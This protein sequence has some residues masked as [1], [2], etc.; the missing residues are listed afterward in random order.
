[1]TNQQLQALK[2]LRDQINSELCDSFYETSQE[3]REALDAVIKILEQEP[4]GDCVSRE[5]VFD[6]IIW[7]EENGVVDAR[8]IIEHIRKLPPATPTREH[9]EWLNAKVGKLFPSNDFKCNRCGNIL[10]F[11][12]VNAGR[13][14]ANFCPNC[15][16]KMV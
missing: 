16:A 10:D 6:A 4:C 7:D 8:E 15:G 14:D 3:G 11:D 9:G 13:G 5:A 1:M 12:G 2:N